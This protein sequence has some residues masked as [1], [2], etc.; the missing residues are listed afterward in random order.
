MLPWTH[1]SWHRKRHLNRFSRFCTAHGKMS[2]YFTMGRP[3]SPENCPFTWRDMNP[4][5]THGSF[6]PPESTTQTAS[7]AVQPFLQGS[8]SWQTDRQTDHATP[9][10]T[11]GR[12]YVVL[13]CSLKHCRT[14]PTIASP[15]TWYYSNNK[16]PRQHG[17]H[18]VETLWQAVDLVKIGFRG[19]LSVTKI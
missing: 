6:G 13:W 2:L 15:L 1:P 10:V 17:V 7:R 12:I 11:I 16:Y 14:R 8:R 4:H 5:L 19:F 9:S 18:A 3:F